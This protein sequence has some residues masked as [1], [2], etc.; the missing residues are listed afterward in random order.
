VT[1]DKMKNA[2]VCHDAGGAE[3]IS[4]Y[5]KN[6]NNYYL[7]LRGPAKKIFK[8]KFKKIYSFKLKNIIKNCNLILCGTSAKS[9]LEV[10]AIKYG[11][12][13]NIKT[14]AFLEHWINYKERF[15]RNKKLF[16]PNEI[17]V[18]DKYAKKIAQKLFKNLPVKLISNPYWKNFCSQLKKNRK[19]RTYKKK[20]IIL[21]FTENL[22]QINKIN[23]TNINFSDYDAIN[24][25]FKKIKYVSKKIDKI[26]FRVHPSESIKKY[27][28]II[29]KYSNQF[30]IEVS[31]K[32]KLIEDIN[33]CDIAVGC[34]TM[35]MVM[36]LFA[37]KKVFSSVPIKNYNKILP[38]KNIIYLNTF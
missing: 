3:I 9:N 34:Q 27:K 38:H 5:I 11:R 26:I 17:Y 16:L 12:K 24:F 13:F 1:A 21:Y 10:N 19:K 22:K 6:V 29:L 14:I 32:N 2:I 7:V 37:K 35:A 30:K 28:K 18:G 4:N 8:N 31:K 25:F 36:A 33:N 23:K 20:E 15:L